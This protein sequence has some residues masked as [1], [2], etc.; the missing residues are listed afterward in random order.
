MWEPQRLTT[1]WA[2]AVYYWDSL[3]LF[4]FALIQG[5]FLVLFT[6]LLCTRKLRNCLWKLVNR[7][8]CETSWNLLGNKNRGLKWV[9]VLRSASDV[10]RHANVSS[11]ERNI[12]MTTLVVTMETWQSCISYPGKLLRKF[13]LFNMTKPKLREKKNIIALSTKGKY[14]LC[15]MMEVWKLVLAKKKNPLFFYIRTTCCDISASSVF[16]IY[17]KSVI[18]WG[19]SQNTVDSTWDIDMNNDR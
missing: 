16:Q 6:G 11:S 3:T 5:R 1:Q 13:L 12:I 8:R 17:L 10:I 9:E 4:N 18:F 15:F 7:N 2:S 14:L 19:K